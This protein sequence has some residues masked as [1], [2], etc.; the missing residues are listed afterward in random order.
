MQ[1][2]A[3]FISY[4]YESYLFY[5]FSCEIHVDHLKN[6]LFLVA[7][8]VC[9]RVCPVK[10]IYGRAFFLSMKFFKR[11][12]GLGLTLVASALLILLGVIYFMITVWIVKLG[13]SWA[14]VAVEGSTIVLTAGI[15]TAAAMIG[16]ALQN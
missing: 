9:E 6:I 15:V 11:L 2:L 3:R 4:L 16:S 13:A 10:F 5:C 8:I 14:Q 12:A 7:L 1:T